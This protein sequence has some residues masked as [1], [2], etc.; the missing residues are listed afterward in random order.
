MREMLD[1][2]IQNL[3]ISLWNSKARVEQERCRKERVFEA[4]Q[5]TPK[6]WEEK[7][8]EKE[9]S[10]ECEQHWKNRFDSL[11][12]EILDWLSEREHAN[13]S[14]EAYEGTIHFLHAQNDEYPDKLKSLV[15]FCNW[16][17]RGMPWNLRDALEGQDK[18]KTHHSVINFVLFY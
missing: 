10:Q 16:I 4:S 5:I 12:E 15:E 8:Q 1:A 3:S 2:H 13:T 6:I 18:N 11:Q 17:T 9:N 14:L 7:C